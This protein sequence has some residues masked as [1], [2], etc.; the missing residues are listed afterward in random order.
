MPN[1]IKIN[2]LLEELKKGLHRSEIPTRDFEDAIN[3]LL[4]DRDEYLKVQEELGHLSAAQIK[5]LLA[6]RA[7]FD[8]WDSMFLKVFEPS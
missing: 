8:K 7:F 5:Y 1:G 4:K 2:N 3:Q 6:F